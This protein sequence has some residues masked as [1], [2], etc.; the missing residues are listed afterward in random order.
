MYVFTKKK[1]NMYL[2]QLSFR[3]GFMQI[4]FSELDDFQ[5]PILYDELSN[6]CANPVSSGSLADPLCCR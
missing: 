4:R 3:H 1:N 2:Y 5:E 6:V